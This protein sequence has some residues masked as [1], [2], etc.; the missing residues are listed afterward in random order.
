MTEK[1][2][3]FVRYV[4]I[5]DDGYWGKAPELLDALKNAKVNSFYSLNT[6]KETYTPVAHI[7]RI[8]LDP[9]DSR[10]SEQTKADL[11]RSNIT[12]TGYEDGDLIEPWVNDWGSL[13]A[14]GAKSIEEM[15][16]LKIK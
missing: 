1:N 7:Y 2:E 3:S 13:Q 9:V 6:T 16:K 8:E 4:V 11:K 14:W 10:W 12:L 5:T 15:I